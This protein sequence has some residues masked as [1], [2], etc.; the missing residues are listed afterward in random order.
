MLDNNQSKIE[1]RK[2]KYASKYFGV[3]TGVLAVI[4]FMLIIL[5]SAVSNINEAQLIKPF[6]PFW[7]GMSIPNIAGGI[8]I[9]F[10]WG[11]L[12][13]FFFMLIYNFFDSK[14]SNEER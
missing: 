6:I 3:A 10:I 5:N 4:L 1:L 8:F 13:G 9:S 2:N 7:N 12:I 14:F 11:W